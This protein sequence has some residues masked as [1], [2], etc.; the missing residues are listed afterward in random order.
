IVAV[1]HRRERA[2]EWKDLETMS[3][4]VELA[5]NLWSK[6]RNDVRTDRKLEP[7]KHLLRHRRAAQ[8]MPALQHQNLFPRARE[9]RGIHQTV[10]PAPDHDDVVFFTVLPQ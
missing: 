9:I 3:R 4:Q 7:G 8:H 6:Q 1:G 10:M 5:N 2:V